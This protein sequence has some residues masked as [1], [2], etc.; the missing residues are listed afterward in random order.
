MR[1][2]VRV[3]ATMN[4]FEKVSPSSP[5]V[6]HER[7]T[8]NQSHHGPYKFCNAVEICQSK[9]SLEL[10]TM[11]ASEAKYMGVTG[12]MSTN[13]PTEQDLQL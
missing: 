11:S 6:D 1:A 10:Y 2:C 12:P 9:F 7:A 5:L 3:N 13:P 8:T 4:R